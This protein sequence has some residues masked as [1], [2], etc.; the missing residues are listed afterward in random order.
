MNETISELLRGA[1]ATRVTGVVTELGVADA[2]A[3]GPRPV[4]DVAEEV[5]ADAD[6]LERFL[7]ALASNGV[8]A[9]AAPGVYR[10]TDASELLGREQPWGA[11]A[12]LYGG[13]WHRVA[14]GLD[15]NG[16]RVV[17]D[18]WAWLAEHEHERAL[19][20]LAMEDGK[21]RRV[22]RLE[23]VSWCGDETVVDVGGGNGSLLI[24]LLAR[25]P[26]LSGIVFDLPETVRDE[27]ELAEAGIEFQA[28]SFFDRVPSA[29]VY[30][31]GT[32]LHN[33]PDEQAGAILRT[34][35]ANAPP[36]ARV[37]VLDLV[38][39]SSPPPGV[40]WF[41]LLGLALFGAR[42]RTESEWRSLLT[43]AGLE[44]EAVHDALIEARC[45]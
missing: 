15:A 23:Q 17:D 37:L 45:P 10:N 11:F 5:G 32:V 9:E 27:D 7:R 12:Q 34:I 14:G 38:V 36:R 44:V 41:D 39:G 35:R 25:R 28:G 24:T 6:T 4:A 20:D 2:L 42:E 30:V 21:E 18:F 33:W 1:I 13:I 16:N 26:G 19:F 40:A 31:L 3:E 8:F 43:N 29:D 22:E